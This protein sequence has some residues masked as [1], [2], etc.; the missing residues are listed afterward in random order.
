M[1]SRFIYSLVQFAILVLIVCVFFGKP[2]TAC[3][4]TTEGVAAVAEESGDSDGAL[5]QD[6]AQNDIGGSTTPETYQNDGST[7]VHVDGTDGMDMFDIQDNTHRNGMLLPVILLIVGVAGVIA[8][9]GRGNKRDILERLLFD[10]DKQYA[11]YKRYYA[12]CVAE[13]NRIENQGITNHRDRV[14]AIRQDMA[15]IYNKIFE[16]KKKREEIGPQCFR[17]NRKAIYTGKTIMQELCRAE[18]QYQ[19]RMERYLV[20]LREIRG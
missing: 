2:V 16:I 17:D 8:Y 20:D 3:A 15:E 5:L 1:Q 19:K 13:L 7:S 18:R 4:D 6:A 10:F 14:F 12:Y 11:E 9:C